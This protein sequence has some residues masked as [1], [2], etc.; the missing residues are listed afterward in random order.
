MLINDETNLCGTN[1]CTVDG[2]TARA[3]NTI[4]DKTNPNGEEWLCR[5]HWCA[6]K[7]KDMVQEKQGGETLCNICHHPIPAILWGDATY[8]SQ[9]SDPLNHP[10]C[11]QVTPAFV[12]WEQVPLGIVNPGLARTCVSG[13]LVGAQNWGHQRSKTFVVC[14]PCFTKLGVQPTTI[15]CEAIISHD[16]ASPATCGRRAVLDIQDEAGQTHWYC[17][18]HDPDPDLNELF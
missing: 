12:R 10:T 13:E 4:E 6:A 1:L 7:Q 5:A 3:Y 2:C 8:K 15:D 14:A 17:E 11:Y 18:N 16:L 9:L